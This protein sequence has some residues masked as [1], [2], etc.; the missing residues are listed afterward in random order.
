M[1][2]AFLITAYKDF[3]WIEK[4]V[5]IYTSG[6][7]D[8]YIHMDK[9]TRMPKEFTDWAA[10]KEGVFLYSRYKINWGSYKHISAVLFLIK[11]ALKNGQYDYFHIISGNS[12]ITRPIGEVAAFFEK[13]PDAN[14][15]QMDDLDEI[16][17]DHAIDP[18]FIY[19]HFLHWYDKKTEFG[20]NFD[21]YFLKVQSRLGIRRKL[22]FRYHGLFYSHLSRP[23]IDYALEF[24]EKNPWYLRQL[25]T[26]NIG[27]EFFF[28]NM[29]MDS[30]YKD[31]VK[32]TSLFYNKWSPGG[33]AQFLTEEDYDILMKEDYLFARKFGEGSEE[34]VEHMCQ[35]F[36]GRKE[37]NAE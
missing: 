24:V 13:T 26:C 16:D 14:Y 17:V 10:E 28:H 30:P 1:R 8:C 12:F 36:A 7:I 32:N 23:F 18:W 6:G 11:E 29:I 5:D 25:K 21:Y 33:V 34:L 2:Q 3:D 15:I 9:K 37:R 22:R 31:T 20:N 19:Y 27:E 35:S 4:T